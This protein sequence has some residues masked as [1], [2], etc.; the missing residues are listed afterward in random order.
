MNWLCYV[1]IFQEKLIQ[2]IKKIK[3]E[4]DECSDA[5]GDAFVEARHVEVQYR[6]QK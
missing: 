2:S 6:G 5:E 1:F 4:I 3:H